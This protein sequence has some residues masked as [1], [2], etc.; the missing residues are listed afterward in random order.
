M[1]IELTVNDSK[2]YTAPFIVKLNQ[3]LV[4]DTELVD[5]ICQDNE[6]SLQHFVFK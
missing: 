3:S 1:E 2:A 4:A 6:K 5:Y